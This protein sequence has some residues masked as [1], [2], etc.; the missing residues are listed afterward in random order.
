MIIKKEIKTNND[1]NSIGEYKSTGPGEYY[2]DFGNKSDLSSLEEDKVKVPDI[3]IDEDN[4]DDFFEDD[5][6]KID[7]GKYEPNKL[8]NEI[9]CKFEE[10][11]K[12][13]EEKKI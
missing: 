1:N 10:E 7:F 12:N 5:I 13:N 6:S 8:L 4:W 11:N 9:L 3:K 2:G